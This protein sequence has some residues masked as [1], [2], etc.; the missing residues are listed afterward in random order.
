MPDE[1]DSGLT[2]ASNWEQILAAVHKSAEWQRVSLRNDQVL[3]IARNVR[4][5]A[6]EMELSFSRLMAHSTAGT[7]NRYLQCLLKNLIDTEVHEAAGDPLRQRPSRNRGT[8]K[9]EIKPEYPT[10]SNQQFACGILKV[11]ETKELGVKHQLEVNLRERERE[12]LG[13]RHTYERESEYQGEKR[14]RA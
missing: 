4:L 5:D 14:K 11:V 3:R 2:P 12:G 8:T 7:T 6:R 13:S 9:A 1:S 10:A